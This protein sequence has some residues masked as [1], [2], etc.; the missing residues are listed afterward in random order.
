MKI[1][2]PSGSK[3]IEWIIQVF[4]MAAIGYTS[5]KLLEYRVQ[6]VEKW[7]DKVD[8]TEFVTKSDLNERLRDLRWNRTT[9]R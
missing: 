6:V 5:F 9:N 7:K 4:V 2:N 8:N 1:S 3:Y